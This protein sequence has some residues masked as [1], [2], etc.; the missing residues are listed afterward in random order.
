MKSLRFLGAQLQF[1]IFYVKRSAVSN[2]MIFFF[3]KGRFTNFFDNHY[4]SRDLIFVSS[5]LLIPTYFFP[6]FG[7]IPGILSNYIITFC[8]FQMF[9]AF[10]LHPPPLLIWCALWRCTIYLFFLPLYILKILVIVDVWYWRLPYAF[11]ICL[12]MWVL[13]FKCRYL[14]SSL[15]M[16]FVCWDRKM[17]ELV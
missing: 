14:L 16:E 8:E 9:F 2:E 6:A 7:L 11:G 10:S 5:Q 4:T 1:Q 12:C 3:S 17:I 13:D 15:I